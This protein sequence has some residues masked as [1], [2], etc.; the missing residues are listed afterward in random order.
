MFLLVQLRFTYDFNIERLAAFS[1]QVTSHTFI[2]TSICGT[3]LEESIKLDRNKMKWRDYRLE[4]KQLK[5]KNVALE[6]STRIQKFALGISGTTL[7]LESPTSV[8]TM[9]LEI[10]VVQKRKID[11]SE[12]FDDFLSH[13][14]DQ[15]AKLWEKVQAII[16]SLYI[17]RSTAMISALVQTNQQMQKC[18][19]MFNVWECLRTQDG[20]HQIAAGGSRLAAEGSNHFYMKRMRSE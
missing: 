8:T 15:K 2:N 17:P 19:K 13:G 11:G 12:E 10:S 3:G 9:K 16:R 18:Q 1:C 6:S 7:Q 20:I 5:K 4:N 14:C